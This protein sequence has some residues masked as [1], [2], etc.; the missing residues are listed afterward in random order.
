MVQVPCV[1]DSDTSA[2]NNTPL[3][4]TSGG[5]SA[6]NNTP[7]A[8][9][10]SA[11][12]TPSMWYTDNCRAEKK[13]HSLT[14]SVNPASDSVTISQQNK[15]GSESEKTENS[16]ADQYG[17]WCLTNTTTL[18]S[19]IQ[20]VRCPVCQAESCL[21]FR[22]LLNKRCGLALCLQ[23]SCTSCNAQFSEPYSSPRVDG[24]HKAPFEVNDRFVL[25][26]REAG[27]GYSTMRKFCAVFGL[28]PMNKNVYLRKQKKISQVLV[29]NAHSILQQ[30]VARVT[31]AYR[32]MDPAFDGQITVS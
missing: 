21:E 30:S 27:L 24:H 15:T 26:L 1:S 25:F 2:Q 5:A 17:T 18:N 16:D 28:Q 13:I 7:L 32:E 10:S 11:S 22:E 23:L 20:C 29:E 4:S 19:A 6:Q 12:G 31:A 8:S 3:A 9:T 14:A